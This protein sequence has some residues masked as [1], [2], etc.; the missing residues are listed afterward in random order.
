MV[1]SKVSQAYMFSVT[2]RLWDAVWVRVL[3]ASRNLR[4]NSGWLEPVRGF[5]ILHNKS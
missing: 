3:L 4:P 2:K 5:V 1:Y